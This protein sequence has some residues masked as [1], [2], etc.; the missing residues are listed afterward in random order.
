MEFSDRTYK[1][2]DKGGHGKIGFEITEGTE[3]V[4]VPSVP[5]HSF[6]LPEGFFI[7][8]EHQGADWDKAGA[9]MPPC[10]G[11]KGNSYYVT[12]KAVRQLSRGSTE[13]ELLAQGVLELGKY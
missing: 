1:P 12:V 13:F 7:V 5:A 4:I 3:K 6:D 2:M 11:G 10:S 8:K 9:Y